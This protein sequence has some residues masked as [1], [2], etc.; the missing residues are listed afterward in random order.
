[1]TTLLARLLLIAFVAIASARKCTLCPHGEKPRN[2]NVVA[3][4]GEGPLTCKDIAQEILDNPPEVCSTPFDNAFQF[5]CGCPGVKA[6]PCPGI[7]E[8][9]SVLSEP[10]Q[11][12]PLYGITCLVADQ[13]LRGSPGDLDCPDF[14]NSGIAAVCQ[15]K[16]KVAHSPNNMGGSGNQGAGMMGMSAG[17][18]LRVGG[19]EEHF[20]PRAARGLVM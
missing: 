17:R 18:K 5:V 14:S 13:I 6:G 11:A 2:G 10:E 15:C 1:M 4:Q 9:G 7:C 19:L 20:P 12:T 8:T 3:V 16:V